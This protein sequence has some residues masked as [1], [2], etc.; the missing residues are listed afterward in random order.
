MDGLAPH[1]LWETGGLMTKGKRAETIIVTGGAGFIGSQLVARLLADGQR[2]RVID[3]LSTGR[4]ENLDGLSGAL[5]FHKA[6][7]LDRDALEKVFRGA[8]LC[9][10]LAALPSV[11]R[12]VAD[13]QQSH[14]NLVS[15]TL[16]VLLTARDAKLRRLVYAASSSAYGD[17]VADYKRESLPPQPIS[18]YAAAKLAGEYYCQVF[19]RTYGLETIS[20]RYFNVFG[21]RQDPHSEYAAVIPRFIVTMLAGERPIIYGDGHQSR[22]FTYVD[23][24]VAGN[25][26]A[27]QAPGISGQTFNIATGQRVTVLELVDKLNEILGSQLQPIH[28]DIRPG[29]IRH[30]QADTQEAEQRLGYRAG[31]GILEGLERTVAWF[32]QQRAP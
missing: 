2:V 18:P 5:D 22:D 3:N 25:C 26:A 24:V 6:S 27:A 19:A 32:L 23:N 13:P 10:H 4:I 15:G 14:E 8:D 17:A 16:N 28:S 9:H 31:V 7:I 11:V 29:D 20:L 1:S 12:S 21:P 30:S